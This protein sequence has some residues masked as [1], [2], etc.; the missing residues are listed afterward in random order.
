MQEPVPK[1][2]I[3]IPSYNHVAWL[4]ETLAS[5]LR[6]TCQDWELIVIDDASTDQSWELLQNHLAAAGLTGDASARPVTT[7][8][9]THNQGAPAA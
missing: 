7:I 2:S 4:E 8:R 9:H 3:L 5:V 1:V 6:Q